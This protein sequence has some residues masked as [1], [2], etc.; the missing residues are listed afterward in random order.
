M[1]QGSALASFWLPFATS[2]ECPG[3]LSQDATRDPPWIPRQRSACLTGPLPPRLQL[4]SV[5]T[6]LP[7]RVFS[8]CKGPGGEL[9][10]G[11]KLF[12]FDGIYRA[13]R[14]DWHSDQ[15]RFD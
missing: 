14:W 1:C 12:V 15:V 13:V 6:G 9:W 7:V 11:A 2:R 4:K 8:G 5:E 10:G 3:F